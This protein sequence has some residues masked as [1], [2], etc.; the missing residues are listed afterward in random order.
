MSLDKAFRDMIRAE[1]E[2]Q[3][4]PLQEAVQA[5]RAGLGDV[6]QMRAAAEALAPVASF[7]GR[8][9][10]A[11]GM[12]VAVPQAKRGPGRPRKVAAAAK[13]ERRKR[14]RPASATAGQVCAIKGCGKASRTKGYCS[15]HY[16]KLRMLDRSGRRPTAWVDYAG[17]ASVEDVKLP[18]GRAASKALRE[19]RSRA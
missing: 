4:R 2:V 11:P 3:L 6:D 8:F 16:Q 10:G 1:V 7:M 19:A 15:A 17:P 5:L 18:R 12:P 14:G 9:M 13:G